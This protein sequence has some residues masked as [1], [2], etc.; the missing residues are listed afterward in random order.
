MRRCREFARDLYSCKAI[1]MRQNAR[2][3][4][5]RNCANF[6]KCAADATGETAYSVSLFRAGARASLSR[7]RVMAFNEI[8]GFHASKRIAFSREYATKS[9]VVRCE[10]THFKFRISNKICDP[11]N[12]VTR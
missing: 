6:A 12:C 2:R 8:R 5:S 10:N 3:V 7:S 9:V 4:L 11:S 1:Q